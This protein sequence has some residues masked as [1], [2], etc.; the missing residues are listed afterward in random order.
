MNWKLALGMALTYAAPLLPLDNSV[1]L[2]DRSAS[3]QSEARTIHREF[4]DGEICGYPKPY[5]G[6]VAAVTW[7]SDNVE[8]WPSAAD[9]PAGYV[10]RADISV[11]V[12]ILANG[13]TVIDFRDDGN[14]C[15]SGGASACNAA[16]LS[17][18]AMIAGPWTSNVVLTA[19]SNL[20]AGTGSC[21]FNPK[22]SITNGKYSY[23]LRGPVITSVIAG[24]SSTA[25][26]D[27]CGWREKRVYRLLNSIG[28]ADTA[29]NIIDT[30]LLTGL[31][32]PF[33]INIDGEIMSV[34]YVGTGT[35]TIG[36]TNGTSPGCAS[37]A[38][39]GLLGSVATS[40]GIGSNENY[41]RVPITGDTYT[42][43]TAE[44]VAYST[45]LQVSNATGFNIG[46]DLLLTQEVVKITAKSGNTLTVSRGQYGTTLGFPNN[47]TYYHYPFS[48]VFNLSTMT[49]RWVASSLSQWKSIHP[50][51]M[52]SFFPSGSV[53]LQYYLSNAWNDRAADQQ[54]TITVNV[55]GA[56]VKT[57][58]NARHIWRTRLV[59]PT[60]NVAATP[61]LYYW[62]GTAPGHVSYDLNRSYLSYAKTMPYDPSV[63]ITALAISNTLT[64][65]TYWNGLPEPGWDSSD[66]CEPDTTTI[67][68][69]TIGAQTK[70]Q[71]VR[72]LNTP[73]GRPEIGLFP[74][75]VAKWVVGMGSGTANAWRLQEPA[76]GYGAC[77]GAV[78]M[79]YIEGTDTNYCNGGGYPA[80]PSDKYCGAANLGASGFGKGMSIVQ[81][82]YMVPYLS[83]TAPT[84]QSIIRPTGT[85]TSNNWTLNTGSIAHLPQFSF[86]A[87]LATGRPFY[88]E[89]VQ[90]FGNNAVMNTT[91]YPSDEYYSV[92]LS[93]RQ[94]GGNFAG[95]VAADGARTLAWALR[96]TGL[97]AYVSGPSPELDY[98]N[99]VIKRNMGIRAGMYALDQGQ[100]G[101]LYLPH[102][103]GVCALENYL[104]SPYWFGVCQYAGGWNSGSVTM[105]GSFSYPGALYAEIN[106]SRTF[107]TES[108]W[109]L[110]G[111]L[112]TALGYLD[113]LGVGAGIGID[114]T[115]RLWRGTAV[116]KAT[117]SAYNGFLLSQYQS[118]LAPCRPEGEDSV[119]NCLSQSL[120]A[121]YAFTSYGNLLN[122]W[123]SSYRTINTFTNDADLNSGYARIIRAALSFDDGMQFTLNGGTYKGTRAW[124]WV[125]AN[126]KYTNTAGDDPTW[127]MT[128]TVLVSNASVN[129]AGTLRFSAPNGAACGYSIN[130]ASTLDSG[131]VAIAGG[132][133]YRQVAL[134]ALASGT[135]VR[136]TCGAGR[137][138]VSV[139]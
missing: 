57:V 111:Y 121:P 100:V 53:G 30:S 36:V 31:T 110:S 13:S 101:A 38:G 98:F 113:A 66:F 70:G 3:V 123:V 6:G 74:A 45:T 97:A 107:S 68:Q 19:A 109:M 125:N 106:Q 12:P 33:N 138:T 24:D 15:S 56:P 116:R 126:V 43:L 91:E 112:G 122:G 5:I 79:H 104:Y 93:M 60:T 28:A 7:Q 9:C 34:C 117:D 105:Q 76:V 73:G 40:H 46:D 118:P 18:A 103:S 35:L 2:T 69:T 96:D 50:T 32:L 25:R 80:D 63:N 87:F 82:P 77:G 128:P 48:F 20:G 131:D 114:T 37:T 75:G 115:G 21:T 1:T 71:F 55:G 89:E 22:T 39:R 29:V 83:L 47:G 135:K 137:V 133:L 58:T 64:T 86:A 67:L 65:T 119:P 10:K 78:P 23:W 84:E 134:G 59:L 44:F 61:D 16:A 102:T 17:Q 130:P 92:P 136:V 41:V 139:P 120:G 11:A 95:Y 52:V 81:Y 132:T 42:Y 62:Y 14:Q 99:A 8:R 108:D 4:K 26:G 129:S 72:T 27:D 85:V 49:D 54:Y 90:L 124:Q 88:K 94:R 127:E 51:A